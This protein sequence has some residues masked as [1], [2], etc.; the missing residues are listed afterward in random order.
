MEVIHYAIELEKQVD[1]TLVLLSDKAIEDIQLLCSI[2]RNHEAEITTVLSSTLN[3]ANSFPQINLTELVNDVEWDKVITRLN[4]NPRVL[5]A[6]QPMLWILH[7]LYDRQFQFY[8]QAGQNSP[9]LDAKVFMSSL[10]QVK[11]LVRRRLEV[12]SRVASNEAWG[13]LGFAPFV[14]GKE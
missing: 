2:L 3:N 6:Q 14:L 9:K 13:Q 1:N 8:Y 4:S 7:T 10:A 12:I 11:N 5:L